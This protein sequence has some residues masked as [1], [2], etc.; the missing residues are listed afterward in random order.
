MK[1]E[2]TNEQRKSFGIE[3]IDPDWDIVKL[4]DFS[5]IYF[6]SENVVRRL[7]SYE[8]GYIEREYDIETSNKLIILPRTKRG[9]PKNLTYSTIING[10]KPKNVGFTY[11][12]N[13]SAYITNF[14]VDKTLF[15]SSYVTKKL[16]WEGL[17]QWID[18]LYINLS[19]ENKR[20]I[21]EFKQQKRET[22]KYKLGDII[23]YRIDHSTFGFGQILLDINKIRKEFKDNNTASLG[24]VFGASVLIRVF[25]F[26][27]QTKKPPLESILSSISLPS[28][29]LRDNQIHFGE[30]EIIGHVELMDTDFDFPISF[31]LQNNI[32][33]PNHYLHIGF[34]TKKKPKEQTPIEFIKK[35]GVLTHD[36]FYRNNASMGRIPFTL[37]ELLNSAQYGIDW[38]WNN[39]VDRGFEND[40]RNPNNKQIRDRIFKHFDIDPSWK[41]D[42]IRRENEIKSTL[43]ILKNSS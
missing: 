8:Y 2:L 27:S 38:F 26:I 10:P 21:L 14:N 12:E 15:D 39:V 30:Y 22:F 1:F 42:D 4:N 18:N 29:I 5:K 16:S 13:Q 7:I 36:S 24:M 40:L 41:Y 32:A 6:D 17:E 9:K 35:D 34:V 3:P 19:E 31:G 20:E 43:N 25:C 11:I 28:I 23:T 37:E 33:D